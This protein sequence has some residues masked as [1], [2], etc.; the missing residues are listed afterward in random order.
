LNKKRL[1]TRPAPKINGDFRLFL[2]LLD[3]AQLCRL[4]RPERVQNRR[5]DSDPALGA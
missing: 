2:R 1:P 4:A 3:P 5:P